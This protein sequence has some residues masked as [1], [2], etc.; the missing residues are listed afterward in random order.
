MERSSGRMHDSILNQLQDAFFTS[1]P[2]NNPLSM[3][4][5]VT[6]VQKEAF[7]KTDKNLRILKQWRIRICM[8]QCEQSCSER[9]Y[10]RWFVGFEQCASFSRW[11]CASCISRQPTGESVNIISWL[12]NTE[13]QFTLYHHFVY[14]FNISTFFLFLRWLF[15]FRTF[16]KVGDVV[17][18]TETRGFRLPSARSYKRAS[19]W[20]NSCI[21]GRRP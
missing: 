13:G 15:V 3:S 5:W 7:A 10:W 2:S 8:V 17:Y 9:D 12:F 11:F 16:L 21:Y 18:R 4:E 19:S 1:L 6:K 20:V 14:F